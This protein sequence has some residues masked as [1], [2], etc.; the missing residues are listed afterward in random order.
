MAEV[1]QRISFLEESLNRFILSVNEILYT[2]SKDTQQLKNEMMDF[3]EEMSDFKEEMSDF[4]KEMQQF[5]INSERD[6]REMNRKW[7]D[8]ANRLGT[9]AEDIAAPNI[10]RIAKELFGEQ[11]ELFKG[12]R[13]RVRSTRNNV[14]Y[15]FD[16]VIE[17][18]RKVFLLETKVTARPEHA[19]QM[20]TVV[21]NFYECF[22]QYQSKQLI[23]MFAS[24]SIPEN[25][26]AQLTQLGIYALAM[27]DDNMDLLNFA[28][29]Q[30]VQPA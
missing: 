10:P 8:L 21:Q 18:E 15:E 11:Q 13:L 12:F 2:M 16:G 14:T 5:R 1:K 7:G 29:L 3:K 20:P 23:P 6:R 17:T 25:V 22:P 4:K 24:M 30:S 27:G 9:F 26:V 28:A 19:A